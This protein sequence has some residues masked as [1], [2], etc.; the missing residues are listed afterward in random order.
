MVR[1]LNRHSSSADVKGLFQP[2]VRWLFQLIDANDTGEDT[3][4]FRRASN[5]SPSNGV[6]R[7][8]PISSRLRRHATPLHMA[9]AGSTLSISHVH[10]QLPTVTSDLDA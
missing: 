10:L 5:R 6:L 4:W 3:H 9:T 1:R 7:S 2:T 8:E